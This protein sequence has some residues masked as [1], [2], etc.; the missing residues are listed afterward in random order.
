MDENILNKTINKPDDLRSPHVGLEYETNNKNIYLTIYAKIY[1]K[2]H[3]M[4]LF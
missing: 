1:P 4:L 3:A 2:I